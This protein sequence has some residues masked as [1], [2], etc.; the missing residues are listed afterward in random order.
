[1]KSAARK[2]EGDGDG[3]GGVFVEAVSIYSEVVQES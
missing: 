2:L 1:M 3:G